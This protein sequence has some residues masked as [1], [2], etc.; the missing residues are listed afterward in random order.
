MNIGQPIWCDERCSTGRLRC[1]TSMRVPPSA[2]GDKENWTSVEFGGSVSEPAWPQE[3]TT[4]SG[5]TTSRYCPPHR[6]AFDI[7]G[8]LSARLSVEQG[9]IADPGH[10]QLSIDEVLENCFR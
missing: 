9:V 8:E 1:S 10:H 3:T 4:R 5:G 2:V 7:E 6:D